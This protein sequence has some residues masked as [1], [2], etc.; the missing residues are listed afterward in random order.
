MAQTISIMV[1][2]LPGDD[3]I[4]QFLYEQNGAWQDL[5]SG[6][7]AF[8]MSQMQQS[9]GNQ[10]NVLMQ[11]VENNP[12]AK[13]MGSLLNVTTTLYEQLLSDKLRDVLEQAAASAPAGDPPILRIHLATP[14]FYWVPWELMRDPNRDYL[15]VLFQIARMPVGQTLPDIDEQNPR[16]VKSIHNLLGQTV[17]GPAQAALETAWQ[18]TFVPPGQVNQV[19]I[20]NGGAPWPTIEDVMTAF[21]A[22]ILHLTCHGMYDESGQLYYWAIDPANA[23]GSL[24]GIS[25]STFANIKPVGG[26]PL[27]F[28]NACAFTG[29]TVGLVPGF[30]RD[31]FG[32]GIQNA[33]GAFARISKSVAIPFAKAFYK[34][35]LSDGEPV[36]KALLL[37]KR[38]FHQ[39]DPS[40]PS[41]LFYCL[42]GPPGTRFE[43]A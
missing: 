13:V 26:K 16:K 43:Y 32:R 7:P 29:K 15:G 25:L 5:K 33:V 8:T 9:L 3:P 10:L 1:N 2:A 6:N 42:Y 20:P 30:G 12:G 39:N 34:R 11:A 31:V 27:L 37:T 14:K 21:K 28:A 24:A 38:E 23:L 19:L 4:P 35:L 22:D 18:S 36:G 17:I 40:D 41:H